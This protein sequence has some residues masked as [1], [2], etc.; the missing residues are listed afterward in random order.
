MSEREMSARSPDED[1]DY[2]GEEDEE[3]IDK[4]EV[5]GEEEIKDDEVMEGDR[6]E[7]DANNRTPKV[8]SSVNPGSGHACPF[9]LPQMWT[10]NDFLPK[11][12]SKIFK[13][14]RDRFQIPDHIPIRLPEKFEKCYSVDMEDTGMYDATLVARL[15]LPLTTLHR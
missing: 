7:D 15:R 12:T 14:L 13:N 8:Q 3:E 4:R 5:E 1:G 10:I 9:I 2:I 6:D 11:M